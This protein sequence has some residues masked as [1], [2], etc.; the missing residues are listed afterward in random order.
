[1][2]A[3]QEKVL[4]MVFRRA[5]MGTKATYPPIMAGSKANTQGKPKLRPQKPKLNL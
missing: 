4:E 2:A 1:V 3:H 5:R